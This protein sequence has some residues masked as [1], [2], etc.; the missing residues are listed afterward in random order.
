M[1]ATRPHL[2]TG[3]TIVLCATALVVVSLVFSP[4]RGLLARALR[5]RR[6]FAPVP[7]GA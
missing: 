6:P 1:S 2:P 7:P 3:P 5:G 4:R